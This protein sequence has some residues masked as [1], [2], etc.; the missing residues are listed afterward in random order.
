MTTPKEEGLKPCEH[1]GKQP[2]RF[3]LADAYRCEPCMKNSGWMSKKDWNHR[4]SQEAP[5]AQVE[6][7]RKAL[8]EA[9]RDLEHYGPP[10]PDHQCTPGITAC[11]GLCM[12]FASF[13]KTMD[14]YR[15][16]L[17]TSKPEPVAPVR[18]WEAGEVVGERRCSN[19]DCHTTLHVFMHNLSPEVQA[20]LSGGRDDRWENWGKEVVKFLNEDCSW[21]GIGPGKDEWE[22]KLVAL[23]RQYVDLMESMSAKEGE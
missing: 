8:E 7:Y 23:S 20:A 11:D 19:P 5:V 13:S 10:P 21:D 2:V 9:I 17:L 22:E 4:R 3:G 14:G 1:C 16:A 12:D 6:V 18:K 15:K